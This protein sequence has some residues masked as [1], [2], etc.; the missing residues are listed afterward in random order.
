MGGTSKA[1]TRLTRTSVLAALWDGPIESAAGQASVLLEERSREFG[2][3]LG[4]LGGLSVAVRELE[5]QGA[6]SVER[7]GRRT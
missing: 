7:R 3:G 5:G 2:S 1:Q 6:I 4:T